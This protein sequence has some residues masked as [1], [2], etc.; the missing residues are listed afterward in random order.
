MALS[1]FQSIEFGLCVNT[2]D[3]EQLY[4]IP[5]DDSVRKTLSEMYDEF[6]WAYKREEN[7]ATFQPSEKYAATE[8]LVLSMEHENIDSIRALYGE[9]SIQIDSIDLGEIA[10]DIVYYFA[11]FRTGPRSKKIAVKRPSQFKGL[12]KKKLVHFV[13][14]SLKAVDYDVFSLDH[15]FDFIINRHEI[16]ILH[17]TGFVFIANIEEEIQRTAIESTRALSA[18]IAFI[19]F[20]VIAKFVETSKTAGKLIASIKTRDDLE[21]TSQ[22]K[23]LRT[24]KELGLSVKMVKGQ[25]TPE[26]ESVISFLQVL[27]RREYVVDVTDQQ[28][29]IYLAASRRKVR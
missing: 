19:D 25:V 3:G 2:T 9:S 1:D 14:D 12:L 11:I 29:E 26:S 22:K 5:V 17:P 28:P 27:D 10:N 24:C 16:E 7:I 15:D 23:L 20:D 6:Y 4:R 18:R 8:G 13:D 21:L